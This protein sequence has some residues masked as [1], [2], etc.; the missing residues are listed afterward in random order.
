MKSYILACCLCLASCL[1]HAQ[2]N[3]ILIIADDLGADY[4]GFFSP[5]TDTAVTPNLRSLAMRGVCFTK[6]WAMPVCSPT[7]ATIMSGRFPFRHGVGSVITSASSAQLDTAEM[8]IAKL[9]KWYAPTKYNTACMGKWHLHNNQPSKRL[10]PQALGFDYYAGNF[11]GAITDYFTYPIIRNGL[12]DTVTTYATT[13]TIDDAIGWLDTVNST[14]PFFLWLAF[15]APHSP[16]HLPPATLCNT[17]GLNGTAADISANPKKYFKASIQAM[18]SEIGRLFNYLS[19]QGLSDSTNI[20]FIGDNGNAPP[21]AQNA[22]PNNAKGTIYHYG[23]HVPMVVAGPAVANPNRINTELVSVVDIYATIAELCGYSNWQNAIPSSTKID[24]KSLMPYINYINPTHRDWTFSEMFSNPSATV[25]GKTI[26]NFGY[27]LM[28]YDDGTRALYNMLQDPDENTNLLLNTNNLT[29]TDIGNYHLLCDSLSALIG[30]QNCMP[31]GIGE[32]TTNP[33]IAVI[34]TA[35]SSQFE[36]QVPFS[37][38]HY[39]VIVLDGLGKKVF[40][41]NAN[42]SIEV[43]CSTWTKGLYIV[44]VRHGVQLST[45]RVVVE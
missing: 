27:Q 16:Y 14:K 9:L 6:V 11:N 29:A 18:D 10:Y 35:T 44:S 7:R 34:P 28:H 43:N 13:Q 8:G 21:V 3:T 5:N 36:I 30:T 45:H 40:E 26:R 22:N 25:D 1:A 31:L 17:T 32:S 24:S 38:E 42:K 37:T 39:Q 23:V 33:A 12:L 19:A 2:Q 15:N 41:K 20:I 4:L